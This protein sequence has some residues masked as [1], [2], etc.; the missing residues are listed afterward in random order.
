MTTTCSFE[1]KNSWLL[2]IVEL[3][4]LIEQKCMGKTTE[5]PTVMPIHHVVGIK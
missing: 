4:V 2:V 3:N 1:K 5:W